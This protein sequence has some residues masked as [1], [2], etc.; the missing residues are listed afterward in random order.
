MEPKVYIFR[1]APASGKGTVVPPFA[2]QLPKPITLIEQD[3]LRWGLHLIGRN[4]E[5]VTEEEHYF[6]FRNTLLL[7]EEYLKVRKYNIVLEGLFTWDDVVASQGNCKDLIGLAGLYNVPWK[8]I[9]LIAE[10]EELLRRNAARPYATP[11]EE[12]ETLYNNIYSKIDPQEIV[13][14]SSGKTPE[15]TLAELTQKLAEV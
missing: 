6:A 8:S 7:Y 3:K 11:P 2:R 12:F 10:K 5:D 4:I 15:Q 1:G 13:I 14:D 9:V